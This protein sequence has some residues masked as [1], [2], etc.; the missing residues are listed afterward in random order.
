MALWEKG[1]SD[2]LEAQKDMLD[3]VIEK[4]DIKDGDNILDLGCGFGSFC[5]YILAKF[6]ML[7]LFNKS[8]LI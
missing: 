6:P 7:S 5:N 2:I 3:D 8:E 4:L 1:A